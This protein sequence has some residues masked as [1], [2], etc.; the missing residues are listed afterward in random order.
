[1][2]KF[3]LITAVLFSF[4]GFAQQESIPEE[5]ERESAIVLDQHKEF[6]FFTGTNEIKWTEYFYRKIK[7]IDNRALEE[8]SK[9]YFTTTDEIN[10][11]I[12]KPD[13]SEIKI[14]VEKEKIGQKVEIPSIFKL[15]EN[16]SFEKY[17]KVAIRGLEKG[18]IIEYDFKSTFDRSARK[19]AAFDPYIMTLGNEAYPILNQK[20][21]F[22]VHKGFY[23]NC[24]SYN[25]AG[26]IKFIGRPSKEVKKRHNIINGADFNY[27][28]L[29]DQNRDKYETSRFYYPY[30]NEPCIKFQAYF[31]KKGKQKK[32]PFPI[33]TSGKPRSQAVTSAELKNIFRTF[34]FGTFRTAKSNRTLNGYL[35]WNKVTDIDD[36]IQIAHYHANNQ[37]TRYSDN[38]LSAFCFSLTKRKIPFRVVAACSR[39]SGE[40]K[41]ALLDE[42]ITWLVE[43]ELEGEKTYFTSKS[44]SFSN[45][46]TLPSYLQGAEA[47][48]FEDIMDKDNMK[49]TKITLPFEE[50]GY[51]QI[52]TTI[53]IEDIEFD[54][55]DQVSAIITETFTGNYKAQRS[56]EIHSN[57][58]LDPDDFF[59][60]YY[61]SYLD[62]DY[63][64][65]FRKKVVKHKEDYWQK[66]VK[67]EFP[68]WLDLTADCDDFE[69]YNAGKVDEVRSSNDLEET[70][71]FRFHY[72][73][74][75]D[76]GLVEQAGGMLILNA[77][78]LIGTQKALQEDEYERTKAVNLN[79][80]RTLTNEISI[81]IPWGYEAKNLDAFNY[82]V[83]TEVG[84]F[85]SSATIESGKVVI[86]TEKAYTSC[87]FEA[88]KWSEMT[89]FLDAA[90]DF[91]Q[92]K[93]VFAKKPE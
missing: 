11:K 19:W 65:E 54:M 27:F 7:I 12:I 42:E 75:F 69:I 70:S 16:L 67:G 62:P 83:V 21:S 1:M 52:A 18:D 4:V 46:K 32:C 28:Q 92:Q 63:K 2:K 82:D 44:N 79:H 15:N 53:K 38:Y 45:A 43:V 25:G 6:A 57:M 87:E 17:S 60:G 64:K 20:V 76:F 10:I 37:N 30:R 93:L 90:W 22:L 51:T 33:G 89:K 5:W 29:K 26:D 59:Q 49:A 23:L 84:E 81:E 66:Y 85:K 31:V 40:L 39:R 34:Y 47:F 58:T 36:I 86:K 68:S 8:F 50:R 73:V 72:D 9:L 56:S 61:Y 91:T 13:G 80:P 77:G 48:A 71:K 78:M 14:D 24:N 41:D 74:N 3:I 55:E 88:E 35:K